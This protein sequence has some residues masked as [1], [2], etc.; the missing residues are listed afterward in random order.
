MIMSE[1]RAESAASSS[2]P[3]GRPDQTHSRGRRSA[4]RLHWSAEVAIIERTT[5]AAETKR[6]EQRHSAP[7][8]AVVVPFSFLSLAPSR[9]Q[10][11]NETDC[12]MTDCK[13]P[14]WTIKWHTREEKDRSDADGG[15]YE[16][17]AAPN[18]ITNGAKLAPAKAT[19]ASAPRVLGV[20]FGAAARF[21]RLPGLF[22]PLSF[23]AR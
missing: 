20:E 15:D 1:T 6:D 9:P 10:Y 22:S 5:V 19:K 4:A 17:E 14:N 18:Y 8:T 2:A 16:E 3:Y 11:P 21:V 13:E 7:T 12:T 23:H